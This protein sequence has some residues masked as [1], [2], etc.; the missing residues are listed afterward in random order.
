MK[1]TLLLAILSIFL[2]YCSEQ[3]EQFHA[4]VVI[5]NGNIYTVDDDHPKAEAVAI[6]KG[7]IVFAGNNE[8][9]E[10]W[11]TEGTKVIDLEGKTMT[12]GLIE[13]HGHFLS[14]GRSKLEVDLNG[15]KSY[16]ELVSRV[17]KAVD[18]ATAG[19]W[20]VGRGWHQSKWD[21]ITAPVFDGFPTHQQLSEISPNNPVFLEHASG[22]GAF[23]NAKA[24]EIAGVNRLAKEGMPKQ[25]VA[26]GE[27]IRDAS[28]NPTGIFNENAMSLITEHIPQSDEEKDRRALEL[29][30][31]ECLKNGITSFEDAGIIGSEIESV[32]K[33][34]AEGNLKV[35][36]WTML[37]SQDATL[38]K[39][40]YAKGPEI[41]TG[42]NHLTIRAIKIM[43]D[44]ALG[45]RGAW[46]LE[47]YTDRENHF[48]VATVPM[49][50]VY[51]TSKKALNHGFQACTHAIG[52]RANREIL[53]MYE[54]ALL[55]NPVAAKDSRFRI[56]HAQH[57]SLQDIPR[58][59]A[60][61]VIPSM[62]AIHLSSDRP[63]AVDRLGEKRIKE[64]AYVWQKLLKTGVK[65]VN[66]TDV[67]VEPINPIANFYASVTRKTLDGT[68][69][70]GYEASQKFTR[71]QAL[72]SMTLDAAYGAF[73]EN[74]KGSI[75]VGKLADFTVYSQDLMSIPEGDI[76]KTKIE[77]TIV[78]GEVLYLRR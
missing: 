75:T 9:V 1:N 12:P 29:A 65:I 17:K 18:A 54:K 59:A 20:I 53:D 32:R 7:R 35:R 56:E 41:G 60:L 11:I 10:K 73:E 3:K 71:R 76:L 42:D 47:E 57:L 68:P 28:G 26:G 50:F 30:V 4:E 34:M 33:F 25:K 58:F 61:G 5:K 51:E 15:T 48:G 19:T 14:M 52:D 62:Q 37:W 44:G 13:G 77:M 63:W 70:G 2:F 64:G 43:A 22:H 21:S 24:M 69:E 36:L 40:W 66:G 23:V 49:S 27:I 8:E 45:S 31:E 74:L 67:P 39:E 72:L 38:L 78:G 46:L 55:E 6:D 16:E